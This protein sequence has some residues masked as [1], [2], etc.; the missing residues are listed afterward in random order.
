MFRSST[1]KYLIQ[2]VSGLQE[3][4]ARQLAGEPFAP[5]TV[6]SAEEGFLVID[7]A[8]APGGIKKLPYINNAFV[9]LGEDDSLEAALLRLPRDANWQDAA[10][11]ATTPN[12]RTFRVMIY[13][14]GQLVAG[15]PGLSQEA[16]AVLARATGLRRD[17]HRADSEFWFTRRRSGRV[18][19]CKRISRRAKTERDLEQGEL[20]PE[21]AR[22]LVILSEP[23]PTDVFLDP[24]AGSGAIAL[25]RAALPYDMI[26]CFDGDPEKVARLKARVK[27]EAPVRK[28]SP[29]I[30]HLGDARKLPRLND[31]FV[32]KVITDPP[33]GFFDPSIEPL[34]LYRDVLRELCRVTKPGGIIVALLGRRE[35]VEPLT[36]AFAEK[37]ALAARY[38][39]LV[40]GKKAV[41]VKWRVLSAPAPA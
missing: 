20:R 31:G 34:A 37:V 38:E 27:E 11:R 12:E 7:T 3:V 15:P 2:C 16:A 10:A 30:A 28:R 41:V 36:E 21:L 23:A 40:A 9:V 29:I 4:V 5:V 1:M 32:D 19:F 13:D 39:I 33:W 18:F 8:A 24:F 25:A 22:L 14:A 26:F 17:P 6:E 35:L